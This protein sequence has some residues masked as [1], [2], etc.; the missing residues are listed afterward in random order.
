MDLNGK[1]ILVTGGT[2]SF[3]QHF[4]RTILER[5][6]KVRRLVIF[7]RDEQKQF[8]MAQGFPAEKYPALRYFIG[9]VRDAD[10]LHR[11]FQNV[12]YVVHAAAMKHVHIAEYNPVECIKT[13]VYGA[14]NV[15]TAA[16]DTNVTRVVALSTD[17]A[18]API[19][20][21]GATKLCSD[22]LFIAANNF[23]GDKD[24]R[25][26]I[27]RYGNVMGSNGSVIPFFLKQRS[28]GELTITEPNMT[29][30]NITLSDGVEMVLRALS[31]AKGGEIFVP[32]IPSYRIMDLAEAVGPN[33]EKKIVGIRPGEKIHEEMINPGDAPNTVEL[34]QG[35]AILPSGDQ[36]MRDAYVREHGARPVES[37]FGYSSGDNK[38]FLDIETIRQLIRQ[39]LD[40]DFS[41]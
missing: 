39:H 3:G 24:I 4:V 10:R 16:L 41:V 14:Q 18:S 17:K 7:S 31:D 32:K 36:R 40:P 19:N 8:Q 29:R 11:A 5:W 27:V 34:D 12:D 2:G 35:Y 33:C 21:Y 1:S 25:F 6:P 26:S 9:D 28:S 20:L 38:D 37:G 13:N 15:I 23:K 30:F 22:K